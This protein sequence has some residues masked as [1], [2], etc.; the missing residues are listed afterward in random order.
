[1]YAEQ[2]E[3]IYDERLKQYF[4]DTAKL[5]AKV[6]RSAEFLFAAAD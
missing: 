2:M 6:P 4:K 5:I 1:M 3:E